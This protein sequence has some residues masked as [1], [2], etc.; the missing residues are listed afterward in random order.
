[1]RIFNAA[2]IVFWYGYALACGIT[3][4]WIAREAWR[5]HRD[6]VGW[7]FAVLMFCAA[8][9]CVFGF[10]EASLMLGVIRASR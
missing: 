2:V 10:L 4:I 1:M 3:T 9:V 8:A 6:P 5:H 7:V